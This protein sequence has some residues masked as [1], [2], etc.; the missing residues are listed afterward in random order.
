MSDTINM[1]FH[2]IKEIVI[3][4]A[5]PHEHEDGRKFFTKVISIYTEDGTKLAITLFSDNESGLEIHNGNL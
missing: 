2:Y 1:D 3:K 4:D 5:I